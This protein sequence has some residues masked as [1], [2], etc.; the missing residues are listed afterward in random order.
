MTIPELATQIGITGRSVQRHLQT[1][2]KN[3]LLR[4]VGGRKSGSWEVLA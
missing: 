2:Q 3:G 1:L 4:R